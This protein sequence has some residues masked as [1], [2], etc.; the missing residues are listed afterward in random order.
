MENRD[1]YHVYIYIVYIYIT[2]NDVNI[3]FKYLSIYGRVR[4]LI[5]LIVYQL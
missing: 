1:K 3:H 2:V 5:S 4:C